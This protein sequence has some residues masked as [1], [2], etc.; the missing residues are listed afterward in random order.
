MSSAFTQKIKEMFFINRNAKQ[1][2]VKNTVWLGASTMVGR[3]IRAI[4]IILAARMLG[5]E[6]YG[7]FSYAMGLAAF[8]SIVSDFG[9]SAFMT[10]E[11]SKKPD[12]KSKYVSTIIILKMLVL[13]ATFLLT[14][15]SVPLMARLPGSQPLV[16]L[17]AFLV[18][19][20]N[21]RSFGFAFSRAQNRMEIEGITIVVTEIAITSLALIALFLFPS[22]ASLSLA[23]I[24]G[25]A[26]GSLFIFLLLRKSVQKL[27]G[28][29]DRTLV[30][31]ILKSASPFVITGMFGGLMI[32]IDTVIL[33]FFRSA[34]ELGL[35]AAAQRPVQL[36]YVLPA[37][38]AASIFPL[39]NQAIFKNET[40]KIR[41][42]LEKSLQSV[43]LLAL[44]LTLGGIILAGPLIALF[45]GS[46]YMGATL[47]F[48]LLLI[49][50][51]FIFPGN[52]FGNAIFSY[53]KQVRLLWT[54]GLAA[55]ANV[56]FDLLLIPR[57]GISGSA[58]ATVISQV[59]V[60]VLNWRILYECIPFSFVGKLKKVF[61]ATIVMSAV[62]LLLTILHTHVLITLG[63]SIIVY[64]G[65]LLLL[66]ESLVSDFSHM[67]LRAIRRK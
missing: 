42:L 20:D 51:L 17:A 45:F 14:L 3:G 6:G 36:L 37:L 35:Y 56:G 23:Y 63:V 67:A 53:D 16:I 15:L 22:P 31:T 59:I 32:N 66:R 44:P 64:G 46:E 65:L 34:E 8:W 43:L 24:I 2:V 49:T 21:I 18:L 50:V 7:L 62:T 5:A 27:Y 40:E 29:F 48:Q 4:I 61:L 1:T 58:V 12:E 25:S 60:N 9:L 26:I 54:T 13:G 52:I 28:G 33:G 57:Y 30:K 47:A 10:R 11:I 38:I 19:F 41:S 55:L 39:L